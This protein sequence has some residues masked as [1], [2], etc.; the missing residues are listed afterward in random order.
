MQIITPNGYRTI[1]QTLSK[2]VCDIDRIGENPPDFLT[3]A[4]MHFFKLLEKYGLK[5]ENIIEAVKKVLARKAS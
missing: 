2:S 1:E 3:D 5:S 4:R